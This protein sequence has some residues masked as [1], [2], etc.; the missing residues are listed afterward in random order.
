MAEILHVII[1]V[2]DFVFVFVLV[3]VAVVVAVAV[4]VAVV[5]VGLAHEWFLAASLV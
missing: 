3:P 2:P 4:A 5:M 1:F